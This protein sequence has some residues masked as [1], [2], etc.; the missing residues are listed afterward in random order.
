MREVG[1]RVWAV[2]AGRIPPHTTGPEPEFTSRDEL[3]ILNATG[4]EASLQITIFYTDRDPVGPYTLTVGAR[5][6]RHVRFNDLI[7]PEA[8]PMATDYAALIESSV[9]IVVQ[10]VRLDSRRAE[11]SMFGS[12]GFAGEG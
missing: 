11:D 7:D 1:S 12:L 9:P 3:C 5:R 4:E 10:H 2:P 6:V 8:I